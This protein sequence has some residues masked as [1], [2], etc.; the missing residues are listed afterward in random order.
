MDA[1]VSTK[2]KTFQKLSLGLEKRDL[3]GLEAES[4]FIVARYAYA[5]AKIISQWT[6]HFGKK[7]LA[8]TNHDSALRPKKSRF[9]K[10]NLHAPFL[11]LR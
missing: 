2:T 9:A 3:W 1:K 7:R 6:D 11:L 4:W 10:P 8:T 5:F